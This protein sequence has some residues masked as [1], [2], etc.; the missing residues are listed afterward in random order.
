MLWAHGTDEWRWIAL[1]HLS[2]SWRF[3]ESSS[4]LG[5]RK[6]YLQQITLLICWLALLNHACACIWAMFTIPVAR[7]GQPSWSSPL[8]QRGGDCG[9]LYAASLYFVTCTIAS[10]GYGD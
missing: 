3:F 8:L 6:S 9:E 1:L 10:V 5:S 2:W 4:P 7:V